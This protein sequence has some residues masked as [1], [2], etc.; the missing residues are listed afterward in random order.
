MS[1]L[2]CR[3]LLSCAATVFER[4]EDVWMHQSCSVGHRLC[5]QL[6]HRSAAAVALAI[7][8]LSAAE[9]LAARMSCLLCRGLLSSDPALFVHDC[10]AWVQQCGSVGRMMPT[11]LPLD[12][13]V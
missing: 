5:A 13:Q 9:F 4:D 7:A 3:G 8:G 11:Q 2:L 12:S 10:D 6:R 1:C